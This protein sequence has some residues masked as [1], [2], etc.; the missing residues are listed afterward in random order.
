MHAAIA[1]LQ[2]DLADEDA[3]EA[4][5]KR[6]QASRQAMSFRLANLAISDE[7]TKRR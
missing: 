6:F 1:E 4:L 2:V 3:V 5:A 7:K